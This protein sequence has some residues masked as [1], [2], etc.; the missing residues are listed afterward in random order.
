MKNKLIKKISIR[1]GIGFGGIVLL[2]SSLF[3]A[4]CSNKNST[5]IETDYNDSNVPNVNNGLKPNENQNT[6]GQENQ[7][8][9]NQES[10]QQNQDQNQNH[11][12][13]DEPNQP[14]LQPDLPKPILPVKPN[15]SQSKEQRLLDDDVF[16]INNANLKLKPLS[17]S[18]INDIKNR[19]D[20]IFDYLLNMPSINRAIIK[21]TTELPQQDKTN[22]TY[23]FTISL[24]FKPLKANTKE[25]TLSYQDKP[26][27]NQ[28]LCDE[29]AS[30]IFIAHG[31]NGFQFKQHPVFTQS[32]IDE[33]NDNNI[34]QYLNLESW[35]RNPNFTYT[36]KIT[37]K[38][39]E[40]N[41]AIKFVIIAHKEQASAKT[42]DFIAECS[43]L[44][45]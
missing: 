5:K 3:L 9:E 6:S 16:K 33:I 28:E 10:N 11:P 17:K 30:N 31:P 1:L 45:N 14:Q 23:T 15:P 13:L 41:E 2:S 29:E 39:V 43:L 26:L 25:F 20:A 32:Q 36:F 18:D 4:S 21:S 22:N 34:E 40:V 7:N 27:S 42:L 8:N 37:N 19:Q 44:P 38:D 12:N 35:V 24:S